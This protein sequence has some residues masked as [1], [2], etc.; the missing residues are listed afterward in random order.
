[1]QNLT[2]TS[3]I[4]LTL[5]PLVSMGSPVDPI[6][7]E[8]R[9]ELALAHRDI[10]SISTL[11]ISRSVNLHLETNEGIERAITWARHNG[12]TKIYLE[13]FRGN[14]WADEAVIRRARDAFHEAGFKGVMIPG[15][16][17]EVEGD[18]P[19]RTRES[20][21]HTPYYHPMGGYRGRAYTVGYLR[22]LL[23]ALN[24]KP[25]I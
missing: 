17:P 12:L 15:H 22:G 18:E 3:A 1:M 7:G 10:L 5:L 9:H 6:P 2:L 23:H 20:I 19:W 4:L 16:V 21:E 25:G 14:M 13:T 8:C 24:G 11:F